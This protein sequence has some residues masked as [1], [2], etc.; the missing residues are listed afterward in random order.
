MG[1]AVDSRLKTSGMTEGGLKPVGMTG[2]ESCRPVWVKA[3]S[4]PLPEEFDVVVRFC[5]STLHC[6]APTTPH[7]NPLPQGEREEAQA[8]KPVRGL[9]LGKDHPSG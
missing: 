1:K 2:A 6:H 7:L 3:G 8:G 5:R 4:G 9:S